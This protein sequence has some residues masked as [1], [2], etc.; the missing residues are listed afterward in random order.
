MAES[1]PTILI[2]EDDPDVAEML[3]AYFRVQGYDCLTANWGEDALQVAESNQ[4]DLALLDIRLPDID[5][6]EVARRLRA[7]RNTR[8]LPIIFL[9]EKREREDKLKGLEIGVEDYITK[10]FD[11]QELRLRVRNALSRNRQNT[12]THPVTGLPDGAL[13]DERLNDLLARAEWTLL[14]ITIINLDRFREAHGF[15]AAD[16]VL[17]AMSVMIYNALHEGEHSDDFVGHLT[18]TDFCILTG[19]ERAAELEKTLVARLLQSLEYFYPLKDREAQ[20]SPANKGRLQIVSLVAS[21]ADGPF[22]SLEA[23]K[24]SLL[25]RPT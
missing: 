1:N 4:I 18:T 10:P 21:P 14:V 11:V 7:H 17:R 23:L 16:D 19:P 25:R 24:S 5:G 6:Y 2:V 22:K 3:N 8:D 13:V 12:L 15:V 20:L 9:T